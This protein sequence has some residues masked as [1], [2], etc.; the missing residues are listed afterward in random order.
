M[1]YLRASPYPTIPNVQ[2]VRRILSDGRNNYHFYHR[3]T[4]T[5]LPGRPGAPEFEA[6]YEAAEQNHLSQGGGK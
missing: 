3:P 4:R 6:A 2:R 1:K 5:K